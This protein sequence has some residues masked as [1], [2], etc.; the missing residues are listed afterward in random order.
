VKAHHELIS[1]FLLGGEENTLMEVWALTQRTYD[2]D[3]FC[4]S[5]NKAGTAADVL[6]QAHPKS[7]KLTHQCNWTKCDVHEDLTNPLV[8]CL[9]DRPI[10][11]Q[12]HGSRAKPGRLQHQDGRTS[13]ISHDV[14][15]ITMRL[16]GFRPARP[17]RVA[18]ISVC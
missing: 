2:A 7:R 17:M 16:C 3:A 12:S 4:G 6:D 18:W 5:A 10:R 14:D 9:Q 15:R 8:K 11:K 13:Y 1:P